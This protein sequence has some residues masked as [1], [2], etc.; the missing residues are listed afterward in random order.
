MTE[1]QRIQ[2]ANVAGLNAFNELSLTERLKRL[3]EMGLIDGNGNLAPA[4]GG[5]AK[6]PK[7]QKKAKH[8][9]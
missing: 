9:A 7:K 1:A 8:A 4:Y 5:T 3:E 2:K 6:R